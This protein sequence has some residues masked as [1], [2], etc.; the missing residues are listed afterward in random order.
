MHLVDRLH[1][2]IIY[3]P[4]DS[5]A[6]VLA[7]WRNSPETGCWI[8]TGA[9]ASQGSPLITHKNVNVPVARLIFSHIGG[10]PLPETWA[11]RRRCPTQNCVNPQH[12]ALR[13]YRQGRYGYTHPLPPALASDE[14]DVEDLLTEFREIEFLNVDQLIA[15]Y[16]TTFSEP[17]IR[18]SFQIETQRREQKS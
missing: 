17:T 11:P 18:K 9:G 8:W 6:R 7:D 12:H 2:K 3:T 15:Q 16:G 1:S 5:I 10:A 4:R 14:Q 13:P